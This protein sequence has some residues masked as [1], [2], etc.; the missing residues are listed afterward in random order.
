LNGAVRNRCYRRVS[1]AGVRAIPACASRLTLD[2]AVRIQ[3][4][5]E[6]GE[7]DAWEEGVTSFVELYDLP[8]SWEGLHQEGRQRLTSILYGFGRKAFSH[9]WDTI[10]GTAATDRNPWVAIGFAVEHALIMQETA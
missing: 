3:R 8:A 1:L 7:E 2:V 9:P 4:L 5:H 6:T 10:H